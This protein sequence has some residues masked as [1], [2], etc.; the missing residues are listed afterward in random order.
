MGWQRRGLSTF[1]SGRSLEG[2]KEH[3]LPQLFLLRPPPGRAEELW[4]IETA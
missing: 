1:Q 4:S 3:E 2:R